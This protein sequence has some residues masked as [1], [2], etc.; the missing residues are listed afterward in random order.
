[1]VR[2]LLT[3]WALAEHQIPDFQFGFCPTRNTNQS[4][5]ILCHIIATAKKEKLKVYTAFL[6]LFAAYDSVPR[7][8]LWRH[9]QKIKTPQYLRDITQNMYTGCLYL[10]IDGDTISEEA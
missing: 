10:L 1:V 3:D 9:L 7:E 2:D 4:L 8:K 5:F 6:D